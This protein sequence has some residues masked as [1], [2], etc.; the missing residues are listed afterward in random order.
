LNERYL[1]TW[2]D[3]A[4]GEKAFYVR[5]V[6]ETDALRFGEKFNFQ[7]DY[8]NSFTSDLVTCQPDLIGQYL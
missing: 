3:G 4:L 6:N 5:L 8:C 2:V 1:N 7:V